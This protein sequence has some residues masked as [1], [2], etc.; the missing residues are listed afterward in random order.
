MPQSW[1]LNRRY[2]AHLS[3]L[4]LLLLVLYLRKLS[5]IVEILHLTVS[6]QL[7][8]SLLLWHCRCRTVKHLLYLS[9][10]LR[11]FMIISLSSLYNLVLSQRDQSS[12]VS[13]TTDDAVL[14]TDETVWSSIVVAC[15]ATSSW[16]KG[17]ILVVVM[18]N[19]RWVAHQAS[20]TGPFLFDLSEIQVVLNHCG[21]L[22]HELI[23]L[24]VHQLLLLRG[25]LID[26]VVA[27]LGE[28]IRPF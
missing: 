16:L 24:K 27:P 1:K 21:S 2:V 23:L 14:E 13:L 19:S 11:A 6:L 10:V 7:K 25:R 8:L 28:G 22:S 9:C 20:A 4:I 17:I 15:V 12:A 18:H 3:I 26:E 5:L